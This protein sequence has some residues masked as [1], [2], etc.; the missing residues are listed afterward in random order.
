MVRESGWFPMGG[1]AA[2][3]TMVIALADFERE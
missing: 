3:R 2:S 1:H